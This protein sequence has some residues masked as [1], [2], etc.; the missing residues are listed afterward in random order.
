V[1]PPVSPPVVGVPRTEQYSWLSIPEPLSLVICVN[2]V[3]PTVLYPGGWAGIFVLQG[4]ALNSSEPKLVRN[5]HPAAN[6]SPH[7][8][9]QLPYPPP[10]PTSTGQY[11]YTRPYQTCT[12][13]PVQHYID[14]QLGAA[15]IDRNMFNLCYTRVC[16]LSSLHL[17]FHSN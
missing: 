7:Q 6:P 10:P 9:P 2:P 14:W 11:A 1:C 5:L 15:Q 13:P 17:V 12:A 4:I 3:F 16:C 8:Y